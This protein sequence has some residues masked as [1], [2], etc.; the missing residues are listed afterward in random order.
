MVFG[1]IL[2]AALLAFE[3]FNYSR[4]VFALTNLPDPNLNFPSN[5]GN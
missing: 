1:S 2:L 4:T 5:A 3:I